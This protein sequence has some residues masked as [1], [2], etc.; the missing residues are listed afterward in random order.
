MNFSAD[1]SNDQDNLYEQGIWGKT[2]TRV[3]PKAFEAE[4]KA[5]ADAEEKNEQAFEKYSGEKEKETLSDTSDFMHFHEVHH[6][7]ERMSPLMKLS[8][9][10]HGYGKCGLYHDDIRLDK[11]NGFK[12]QH[13]YFRQE[14]PHH[15]H[16]K[17]NFSEEDL[18]NG[19]DLRS[20][21]NKDGRGFSNWR[22]SKHP[23]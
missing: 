18:P 20:S 14:A 4:S 3:D 23:R 9:Q 5:T 11:I 6:L 10:I 2:K 16:M 12:V 19:A 21:E 13:M 7:R 8:E 1:A 15:P 17:F 22:L